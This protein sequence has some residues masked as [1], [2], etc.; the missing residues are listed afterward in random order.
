MKNLSELIDVAQLRIGMFV[1]LELGWMAH[2]FPTSSFKI[3][4][5]KQIETIRALGLPKVR[6]VPDKSDPIAGH[7]AVPES[8]PAPTA[9]ELAAQSHLRDRQL[10]SELLELQHRELAACERRFGETIRSYRQVI[11]QIQSQ[12]ELVLERC[13]ELVGSFVS[14]MLSEGDSAIRLLSDGM[15]DKLALH[16]VNVSVIALLLGKFMNLPPADMTELGLAAFLHDVGKSQVPDRVRWMDDSFSSVE[17]K[18]YQRACGTR[19][20]CCASA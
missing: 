1:E 8:D 5:D 7:D 17:T 12:P 20:W 6:F 10:R 14:E 13:L 4:N 3:S 15:G 18:V 11:D 19:A 9:V 2:P 16:P